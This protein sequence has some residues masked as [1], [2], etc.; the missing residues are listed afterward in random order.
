MKKETDFAWSLFGVQSA[1]DA[2]QSTIT[3][4]PWAVKS[5][6]GRLLSDVSLDTAVNIED[7]SVDKI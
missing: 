5:C 4:S 7:L 3:G 1:E 2:E 6:L